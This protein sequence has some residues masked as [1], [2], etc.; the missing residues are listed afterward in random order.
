MSK[1]KNLKNTKLIIFDNDNTIAKV[2]PKPYDF[3]LEVFKET[4]KFFNGKV[5]EEKIKEQ[6]VSYYRGADIENLL[7]ELQIENVSIKEF[8]KVKGEIDAKLRIK[9]I[10]EKKAYLFPDAVNLLTYAGIHGI[11][12]AILTFTTRQV[13]NAYFD[14]TPNLSK[15]DFIFD[16]EDSLKTGLKKPDPEL[17]RIILNKLDVPENK[18][19][20]IGD[21]L[22]DV[23][24]ANKGGI[25][26]ILVKRKDED[27]D[28][29]LQMEAKIDESRK[30]N[31]H[32]LIP[33]FEVNNLNEV[34]IL[35]KGS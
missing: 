21:R 25:A 6:M 2:Y 35:L 7:A 8:Q 16:W 18:A 27:G 34:T 9:H 30:T 4:I 12:V 32:H 10:K 26:S 14:A 15:P 19:V 33:D 20:M 13:V 11:K 29:L 22:S 3:W 17:I 31:T 28:F 24:V 23:E 5:D 1:E